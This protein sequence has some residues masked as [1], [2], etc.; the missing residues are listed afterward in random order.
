M[1]TPVNQYA[2]GPALTDFAYEQWEAE[3]AARETALESFAQDWTSELVTD[4]RCQVFKKIDAVIA[5]VLDGIYT[6][7]TKG[8]RFNRLLFSLWT[9]GTDGIRQI[10]DLMEAEFNQVIAEEFEKATDRR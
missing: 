7:P 6:H 3:T 10:R 9:G 8:E 2:I 5:E 1:Y 4:E